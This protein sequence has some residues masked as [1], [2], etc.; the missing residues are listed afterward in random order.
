MGLCRLSRP[1]GSAIL[2]GIG[3]RL[4]P[5]AP[6]ASLRLFIISRL[7]TES[8]F[9]NFSN[10]PQECVETSVPELPTDSA[11]T[12]DRPEGVRTQLKKNP[13][14]YLEVVSERYPSL[15]HLPGS[16]SKGEAQ[17]LTCLTKPEVE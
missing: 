1:S 6:F 11:R 13:K 5:L 3:V 10:S 17:A 2:N 16:S 15:T 4:A 7:Q 8:N 14:S 9:F 12:T